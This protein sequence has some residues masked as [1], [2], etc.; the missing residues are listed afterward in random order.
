M[1]VTNYCAK[2]VLENTDFARIE[3]NE[4]FAAQVLPAAKPLL[5]ELLHNKHLGTDQARGP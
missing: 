2:P 4:A 1:P 5:R 3:I